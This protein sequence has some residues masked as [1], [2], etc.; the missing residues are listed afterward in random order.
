MVSK[1]LKENH[2]ISSIHKNAG[3]A[4]VPALGRLRRDDHEFEDNLG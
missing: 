3:R 1:F 4:K 2:S